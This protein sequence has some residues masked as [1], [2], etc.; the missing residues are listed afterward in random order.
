MNVN[1]KPAYEIILTDKYMATKSGNPTLEDLIY[2]SLNAILNE[3]NNVVDHFIQEDTTH[4]SEPDYKLKADIA[5]GAVFDMMNLAFSNALHQFDPEVDLHPELTPQ[6][7]LDE[8]NSLLDEALANDDQ[9]TFTQL[10]E[11][12]QNSYEEIQNLSEVPGSS[13]ESN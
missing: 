6:E 5:K 4:A 10:M 13:E 12:D 11:G 1:R 3:A 9:L 7:M 2:S 8:E